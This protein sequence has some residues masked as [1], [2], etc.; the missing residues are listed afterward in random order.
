M[1]FHGNQVLW[2]INYSFISLYSKYQ[3]PS[4]ICSPIMLAP[5]ISSLD[6]IHCIIYAIFD[7]ITREPNLPCWVCFCRGIFFCCIFAFSDICRIFLDKECRLCRI[8]GSC[9]ATRRSKHDR[10]CADKLLDR[11]EKSKQ[12]HCNKETSDAGSQYCCGRVG[13]GIQP[14]S[15]P[16]VPHSH[17]QK[18]SKTLVSSLFDSCPRTDGPTDRPTDRPTDGQSLL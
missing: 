5:V 16:Q 2:G 4:F 17:A 11:T 3:P 10:M 8:A 15:I 12:R 7:S 9:R 1:C 14:L 18:A 13:R 6:E